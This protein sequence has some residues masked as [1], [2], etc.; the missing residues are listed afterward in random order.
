MATT[1][2]RLGAQTVGRLVEL[3]DTVYRE[4]NGLTDLQAFWLA[5]GEQAEEALAAALWRLGD[6]NERLHV[7]RFLEQL[8]RVIPAAIWTHLD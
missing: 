3:L 7:A 6:E 1:E 2:A 4:W 5:D 8:R